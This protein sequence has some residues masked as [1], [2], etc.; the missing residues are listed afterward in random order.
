MI[1]KDMRMVVG[2]GVVKWL[3]EGCGTGMNVGVA[4]G[5]DVAVAAA[6][7]LL[8]GCDLDVCRYEWMGCW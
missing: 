2:M 8:D 3:L 7:W 1:P 6:T 4:V 5:M